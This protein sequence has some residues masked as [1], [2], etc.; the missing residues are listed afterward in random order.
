MF[1]EDIYI[2]RD[3]KT[4]KKNKRIIT[5]NSGQF[6]LENVHGVKKKENKI[7]KELQWHCYYTI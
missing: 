7:L 4:I 2:D 3:A 5:P 1:Y 6:Q